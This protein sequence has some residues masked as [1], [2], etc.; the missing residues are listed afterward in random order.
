MLPEI[1]PQTTLV[2][3]DGSILIGSIYGGLFRSTDDGE[4]WTR[5]NVGLSTA[6]ASVITAAPNGMIYAFGGSFNGLEQ[7]TV[8][9]RTGDRGETWI[10]TQFPGLGPCGDAYSVVLLDN[11]VLFG[12]GCGSG[13]YR[14]TDSGATW[15][16]QPV[17]GLDYV[18]GLV[19]LKSGDL[20]A[21]AK[22]GRGLYRSTDK[23][24]T[25]K[26]SGEFPHWV[27]SMFVHSSGRVLVGSRDSTIH[28]SEDNGA[29][30]MRAA[31]AGTSDRIV[32]MTEDREGRVFAGSKENGVYVSTDGGVSWRLANTSTL[33]N[34]GNNEV[35]ILAD[36]NGDLFL[37]GYEYRLLRS[38][39]HGATWNEFSSGTLGRGTWK[40]LARDSSGYLWVSGAG[41]G[42]YRSTRATASVRMM[43]VASSTGL[44]LVPNPLS[45]TATFSF[46][47][48]KGGDARLKIYD[49]QGNL[50][51]TVVDGRLDAGEHDVAWNAET[52]MPGTYYYRLTLDG[53]ATAG[54]FIVAR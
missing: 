3:P 24:G 52:V 13:I 27:M 33:T 35:T 40:G 41:S 28:Y 48:R 50:V 44:R 18:A 19:L 25:W 2:A 11:D 6:D 34:Y 53:K 23:G 21:S 14:T 9:W 22:F 4:T 36:R 43:D 12:A 1:Y 39:D 8:I 38:I 54:K 42:V 29:T 51:S 49:L 7:I 26:R 45:S 20:L 37:V 15:T 10:P 17:P 5:N 30:W 32:S 47:L 46:T 16:N 31:V